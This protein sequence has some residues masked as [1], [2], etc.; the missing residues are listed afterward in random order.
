MKF[1]GGP[2]E[3]EEETV[4]APPAGGLSGEGGGLRASQV[5]T[6]RPRRAQPASRRKLAP[7]PAPPRRP[8]APEKCG[9]D[10]KKLVWIGG[11]EKR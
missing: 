4:S 3:K 8:E 11:W 5:P 1:S 7:R 6:R 9:E 2:R 10:S